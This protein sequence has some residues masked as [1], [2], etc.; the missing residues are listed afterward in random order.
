VFSPLGKSAR[1]QQQATAVI[2]EPNISRCAECRDIITLGSGG[3]GGGLVY[4]RAVGLHCVHTHYAPRRG[5]LKMR[6]DAFLET[7]KQLERSGRGGRRKL[8]N[9]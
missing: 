6:Q 7:R 2:D 5:L 1:R 8:V 3:G 9:Y 4:L